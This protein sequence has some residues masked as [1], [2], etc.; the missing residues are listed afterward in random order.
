[1][2]NHEIVFLTSLSNT[3]HTIKLLQKIHT[4]SLEYHLG[5][6]KRHFRVCGGR[7]LNKA[8]GK[9][10]P[11]YS[12]CDYPEDL[13]AFAGIDWQSEEDARCLL[14]FIYYCYYYGL[15]FSL[16]Q[17]HYNKYSYY[18]Y[19]YSYTAVILMWWPFQGNNGLEW[20]T[21]LTGFL[22]SV[23][24]YMT[25]VTEFARE[26]AAAWTLQGITDLYVFTAAMSTN[27]VITRKVDRTPDYIQAERTSKF[28]YYWGGKNCGCGS[29]VG[30][31]GSAMA[32]ICSATLR[33]AFTLLPPF[34]SCW[35]W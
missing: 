32:V 6:L 19:Y 16:T 22:G 20:K 2:K 26:R 7:R 33:L 17:L 9:V 30:G 34:Q 29:S 4:S 31:G 3:K 14:K 10:Q 24:F 12:C 11:I 15:F 25:L 21:I 13:K 5:E 23:Q 27:S 28:I 8:K 1:M 18:Y 35:K